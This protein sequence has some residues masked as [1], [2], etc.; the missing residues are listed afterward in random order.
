MSSRT[1]DEV[2]I[3]TLLY[4]TTQTAG[5]KA[6]VDQTIRGDR[7]R[8][9]A[10][11]TIAADGDVDGAADAARGSGRIGEPQ[12]PVPVAPADRELPWL[13]L[14]RTFDEARATSRPAIADADL[15]GDFR[16]LRV[17]GEGG[18]G[19]VILAHQTT[20][21]REVAVKRTKT[22]VID[23][24]AMASLLIEARIMGAL[25]HPNIVPVHILARDAVGNP[26]LVMKHI[27]GRSWRD[28]LLDP[29]HPFWDRLQL[30][31]QERLVNNLEIL[32]SVCTAVHF[33]HSRGV[34]HRD[35]KPENVMLGAFGEV[36]LVD[37]GIATSDRNP[38]GP[39][40]VGT[41]SFMAP[42]ML[43]DPEAASPAT[44]VYL[45]G[46][47][48]HY[49]VT[50]RYRHEGRDVHEALRSV[51]SSAQ[52][53]YGD[54]IPAELAAICRRAMAPEPGARFG[55]AAELR[56]ALRDHLRHRSSINVCDDGL[57]RIADCRVLLAGSRQADELR[58][59][60][61]LFAEARFA[62]E[63]ALR[64]WPENPAALTARQIAIS[65]EFQYEIEAENFTGAERVFADLA[66]PTPAQRESLA[67]L[68]EKRRSQERDHQTLLE[69]RRQNDPRVGME[70][71][72]MLVA[73]VIA[74]VLVLS[75]V[76]HFVLKLEADLGYS[77]M[78]VVSGVMALAA[79]GIVLLLRR[80][81]HYT[82]FNRRAALNVVVAILAGLGLRI[83]SWR[84]QIPPRV[85]L[86]VE[87]WFFLAVFVLNGVSLHATIAWGAIPHL[88]GVIVSCFYPEYSL[89]S[90]TI[91]NIA[92]F[93]ILGAIWRRELQRPTE[94]S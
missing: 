2:A 80:G 53:E 61:R 86:I 84:F 62:F 88:V 63:Q 51:T 71:R 27:E 94:Q 45:I 13:H 10:A 35:I 52:P 89:H 70:T 75:F 34:V 30:Q 56:D 40:V 48:L 24:S 47:T 59:L 81:P 87:Q 66:E 14:D 8:L 9:G 76:V 11:A 49:L 82:A 68:D 64:E 32:M 85:S 54:E 29:A 28:L 5:A 6:R 83:L 23:P 39:A 33:A 20:L 22:D 65:L 93:M 37:W 72:T 41:P 25:E 60:H 57:R 18:M 38:P 69:L 58:Q 21:E 55:S 74:L 50:G 1:L 19:Q 92:S 15:T 77:V 17:L 3:E 42:E 79:I 67:Q 7:D 26:V 44:D 43:L 90:F 73:F 31:S 36:Y 16:P 91:G 46:A 4:R 78:F 12:Q